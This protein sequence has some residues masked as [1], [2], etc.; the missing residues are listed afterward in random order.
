M[1]VDRVCAYFSA[2]CAHACRQGVRVV[3]AYLMACC[4]SV[5]ENCLDMVENFAWIWIEKFCIS[6][7]A[8]YAGLKKFACGAKPAVLSRR[9]PTT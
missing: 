1:L 9:E 8:V 5:V 2:W 3:L 4:S 7:S 6:W